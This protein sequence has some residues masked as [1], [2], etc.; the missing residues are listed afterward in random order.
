MSES[1]P[2]VTSNFPSVHSLD[3]PRREK[4]VERLAADRRPDASPAAAFS[5]TMSL[6]CFQTL[7]SLSSRSNSANTASNARLATVLVRGP[8]HQGQ[9]GSH[10]QTTA[11]DDVCVVRPARGSRGRR[12]RFPRATARRNAERAQHQQRPRHEHA[13]AVRCGP[14]RLPTRPAP[15]D[16]P[17]PPDPSPD[18]P[19]PHSR[20]PSIAAFSFAIVLS[21][22][23]NR[24]SGNVRYARISR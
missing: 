22:A 1:A 7:I 18:L 20:I 10:R 15:P 21:D 3:L 5:R 17:V 13:T 23:T 4:R 19:H 8:R 16:L 11:R 2:N 9:L 6:S 24:S 14:Q 12:R